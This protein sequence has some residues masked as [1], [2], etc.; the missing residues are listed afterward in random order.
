MGYFLFESILY[1]SLPIRMLHPEE[2]LVVQTQLRVGFLIV[3]FLLGIA[4]GIENYLLFH[5]IVGP[6]Y[7]LEKGLKNLAKGELNEEVRIRDTDQL[8]DLIMAFEEMR[9]IIR[10][11]LLAQE[12]TSELMTKELE[13]VL[14][15]VTTENIAEIRQKLK[16]I[17]E[18]A[19]KKAA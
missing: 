13:R 1:S 3:F 15:N 5:S 19:E 18:E 16:Q 12:K 14:S 4:T 2:W 6:L 11:R 17:R 9:K 8:Q 10:Q 7:A